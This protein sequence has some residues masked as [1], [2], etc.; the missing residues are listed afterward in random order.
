[1][2]KKLVLLMTCVL[3]GSGAFAAPSGKDIAEANK[4]YEKGIKNWV[5]GNYL[6]SVN[7]F[8]K[9]IKNNPD[10]NN[11]YVSLGNAKVGLR[12][13]NGA[14]ESFSDAIAV[15]PEDY[16]PYVSRGF[17]YYYELKEP[18]KAFD[19][20]ERAIKLDQHALSLIR[21]HL[22]VYNA[23]ILDRELNAQADAEILSSTK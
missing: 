17:I 6:A 15:C 21:D 5:Q 20:F 13:F 23:F 16:R 3:L 22:E 8:E 4:Y 19:D 9:S 2:K 10:N 18:C 7:A 12:D 14:V 1:M 11:A